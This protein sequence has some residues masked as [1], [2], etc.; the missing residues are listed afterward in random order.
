MANDSSY[1]CNF[2][3][4]N[5]RTGFLAMA[6]LLLANGFRLTA[7]QEAAYDFII[8]ISTGETRFDAILIWLEKN[9]VSFKP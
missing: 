4:G 2:K 1:F 3:Y 6:T 9:T 5:K 7:S 8:K